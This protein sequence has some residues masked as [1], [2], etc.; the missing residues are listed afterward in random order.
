LWIG[1]LPGPVE[2]ALSLVELARPDR[3]AGNRAKRGREYRPIVPAMAFGQAHRLTPPFARARERDERRREKLVSATRDLEV[4]PADL[5]GERGALGKVPLGIVESPGPRLDDPEIQQRDRPQLLLIAI[6]SLDS[7][8]I[9]ASSS[10]PA[11]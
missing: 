6:A 8:E 10:S 4:G 1:D 9:E 3:R 7:F 2:P 5:L 11:R